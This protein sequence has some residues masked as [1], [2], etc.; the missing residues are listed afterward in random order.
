MIREVERMKRDIPHQEEFA[1]EDKFAYEG[2][3]AKKSPL[4]EKNMA[5]MRKIACKKERHVYVLAPISLMH[6]L[7]SRRDGNERYSN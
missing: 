3:E 4:S 5:I 1:Y 7:S 6:G 2:E